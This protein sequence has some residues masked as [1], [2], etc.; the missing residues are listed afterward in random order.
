MLPLDGTIAWVTGGASGIGLAIVRQLRAVGATVEILDARRAPDLP[1][2]EMVHLCDLSD[3]VSVD[4]VVAELAERR[5]RPHILVNSAGIAAAGSMINHDPALWDRIIAVNLTG[6]FNI[7]RAVFPM[8]ADQG[9]GRIVLLASDSAFLA[10]SGLGAYAASK[11]GVV[12]LGRTVATEG[13]PMGISCNILSPGTVDTPMT[14]AHF[15]SSDALKSAV[16]SGNVLGVLLEPDDLA[17]LATFLCL[18]ASRY[19][20]GQVMHVNA[21]GLMR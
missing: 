3:R 11:A 9:S 4:T 12:A 16:A 13:G 1:D 14:Q 17:S 8:M 10:D 19:I 6:T 15:G 2:S 7:I 21:G 20:T 18:P 5:G